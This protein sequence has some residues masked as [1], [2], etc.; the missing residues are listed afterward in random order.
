MYQKKSKRETKHS[1][2]HFLGAQ[3]LCTKLRWCT[4]VRFD[5]GSTYWQKEHLLERKNIWKGETYCWWFRNSAMTSWYVKYP[6]MYLQGF[7]LVRWCR[8]S[9]INSIVLSCAELCVEVVKYALFDQ[10]KGWSCNMRMYWSWTCKST[11]DVLKLKNNF[12]RR[13]AWKLIQFSH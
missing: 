13:T 10:P 11:L 9:S 7:V 2:F 5:G 3:N 12:L 6:I 1:F 4:V 8:I